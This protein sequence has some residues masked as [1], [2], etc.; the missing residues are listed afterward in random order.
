MGNMAETK[1][2]IKKAPEVPVVEVAKSVEVRQEK[3]GDQKEPKELDE[4]KVVQAAEAVQAAASA[5]AALV[6]DPVVAQIE[7]VMSEDLTDLFLALSPEKQAEFQQKGEE[8]ASA[9][10]EM[11]MQAKVNVKKIFE[12]LRDWMKLLPGVNKF[13]LEQEAKIKADKILVLAAE[14]QRRAGEQIV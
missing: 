11:L 14:E 7:S 3:K 2:T 8:T 10:K 9:I 13:F 12:L 5:P 6:K 4:P 1:E